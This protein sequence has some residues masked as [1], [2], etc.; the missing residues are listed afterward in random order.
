[1]RHG[2]ANRRLTANTALLVGTAP[3]RAARDA[4]AKIVHGRLPRPV[5]NLLRALPAIYACITGFSVRRVRAPV[6]LGT[7]LHR[8]VGRGLI[9]FAPR[10]FDPRRYEP[11]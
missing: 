4:G 9:G 6:C 7:T 1:M 10:L 3:V 5:C 2:Q 8:D 11:K